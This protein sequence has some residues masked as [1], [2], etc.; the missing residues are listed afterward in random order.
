MVPA[1]AVPSDDPRLDTLRDRPEIS[2]WRSSG[3]RGL[4]DVDGRSEHD[5][6]TQAD[7]QEPGGEGPGAGGAL[8][9]H[10][11]DDDPNDRRDEPGQDQRALLEPLGQT[12]GGQG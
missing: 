2:P 4:H 12:A 10:E 6:E 9:G 5:A 11:Q 1:I 7:E 3:K 8:D